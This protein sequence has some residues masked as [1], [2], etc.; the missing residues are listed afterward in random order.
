[1]RELDIDIKRQVI[2]LFLKG[3]TYDEIAIQLGI[4]KGSVVTIVNDF[5]E[6]RLSMPSDMTEYV[7]KLRRI[8]VDLRK[9]QTTVSQ[10]KSYARIHRKM[11]EIGVEDENVERW[12]DISHDIASSVNSHGQ[13]VK[14]ALELA[15]L[16]SETGLSCE[17]NVADYKAKLAGRNELDKEID[18]KN[19]G[20]SE[21]K[22]KHAEEEKRARKQLVLI[23]EQIQ[24]AQDS[25]LRQENELKTKLNVYMKQNKLSLKKVN[26][27]LALFDREIKKAGLTTKELEELTER[28]QNTGSLIV[29]NRQLE[30]RKGVLSREIEKHNLEGKEQSKIILSLQNSNISRRRDNEELEKLQHRKE[31]KVAEL[32]SKIKS[33]SEVLNYIMSLAKDFSHN[34]YIAQ[35]IIGFLTDSCNLDKNDIILDRIT[36]LMIAIR[37]KR[38]GS[39][40]SWIVDSSRNTV[41]CPVLRIHGDILYVPEGEIDHARKLLASYIM[42]LVEDKFTSKSEH[43]L[44][45][46]KAV[47]QALIRRRR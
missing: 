27:V 8:A 20:L 5:R 15:R 46:A 30:Q 33:E 23:N 1:M 28:I 6:G 31:I 9:Q 19:K 32:D 25:L 13:F 7:D 22:L 24:A 18:E 38:L 16:Q 44:Q 21:I 42:P 36:G 39:E 47:L 37:Q 26:T 12:I 17:D 43:E 41:Q 11:Q 45:K 34:I 29:A 2:R 3:W 10:V 14:S 4:A 35:L 40:I